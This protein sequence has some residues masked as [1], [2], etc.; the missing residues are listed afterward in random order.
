ME[1]FI[2]LNTEEAGRWGS[3]SGT[4]ALGGKVVQRLGLACSF[5]SQPEE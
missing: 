1:L 5:P 3:R 2:C 4:D